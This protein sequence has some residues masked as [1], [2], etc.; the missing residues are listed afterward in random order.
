MSFRKLLFVFLMLLST[1]IWADTRE[2]LLGQ[3]YEVSGRMAYWQRLVKLIQTEQ[4]EHFERTMISPDMSIKMQEELRNAIREVVTGYDTTA[5]DY[6][7]EM[8]KNYSSSLSDEDLH[9]LISF[10]QTDTG[11]KV[12]NAT[13]TAVNPVA[14]AE[15]KG[16]TEA[17]RASIKNEL[18]S[19]VES[20]T[21][22]HLRP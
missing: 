22:K 10:Y 21:E 12:R 20:I 3:Y 7:N 6:Q 16:V 14:R 18:L 17:H 2:Q 5:D 4:I 1:S 19:R 9:N 15:W 8:T 11:K 13:I